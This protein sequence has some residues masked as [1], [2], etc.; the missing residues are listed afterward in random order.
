MTSISQLLRQFGFTVR[1]LAEVLG[2][3]HTMMIHIESGQ[4]RPGQEYRQ[5]LAHPLFAEIETPE[6]TMPD[7][8]LSPKETEWLQAKLHQAGTR[9]KKEKTKWH[10]MVKKR[11]GCRN[12]LHHTRNLDPEA[13]T[14]VDLIM[15]WWN[16]QRAK[17]EQF[18]RQR[19][20]R[21]EQE[22]EMKVYLLEKEVE[23]LKQ[24]LGL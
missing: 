9:L 3:S 1:D 14:G 20:A 16:W 18:L 24:K 23:Y 17:A 5:T 7:D 8:V 11:D 22:Q 19:N 15:D 4:R 13:K 21:T 10:G 12:I 6:S 2:V